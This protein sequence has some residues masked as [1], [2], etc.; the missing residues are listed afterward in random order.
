M[1]I[2]PNEN[3]GEHITEQIAKEAECKKEGH[4]HQ[5]HQHTHGGAQTKATAEDIAAAPGPVISENI[6]KPATK[7]ELK[8]RAEELNK[9]HG[10]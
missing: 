4:D 10:S 3:S 1:P 7:E 6:G 9:G 8:A 5:H 2:I